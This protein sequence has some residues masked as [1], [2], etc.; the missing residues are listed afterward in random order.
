MLEIMVTQ[1]ARLRWGSRCVSVPG[2][3]RRDMRLLAAAAFSS[4][5]CPN[6]S[7]PHRFRNAGPSQAVMQMGEL[8][9]FPHDSEKAIFSSPGQRWEPHVVTQSQR[10]IRNGRTTSRLGA[11]P[12]SGAA[13][14]LM[15]PPPGSGSDFGQPSPVERAPEWSMRSLSLPVPQGPRS[16]SW[17]GTLRPIANVTTDA[18][19]SVTAHARSPWKLRCRGA[20]P[21]R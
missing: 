2:H 16:A 20:A 7:I 15:A 8:R 9:S 5:L 18:S 12:A 19:S 4:A 17:R 21:G 14:Q 10:A 6:C 11:T 3:M 1:L 13:N